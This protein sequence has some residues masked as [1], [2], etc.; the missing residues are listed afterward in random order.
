MIS[1][2]MKVILTLGG[3]QNKLFKPMSFLQIFEY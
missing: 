1:L 3:L 2:Q